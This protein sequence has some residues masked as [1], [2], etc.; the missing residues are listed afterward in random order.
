[1]L[2]MK[3]ELSKTSRKMSLILE[4]K[5]LRRKISGGLSHA[6]SS[7]NGT[8]K[9]FF[10]RF[11]LFACKNCY[12]VLDKIGCIKETRELWNNCWCSQAYNGMRPTIIMA[13]PVWRKKCSTTWYLAGPKAMLLHQTDWRFGASPIFYVWHHPK[14]EKGVICTYD[15][16]TLLWSKGT[17]R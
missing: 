6:P 12:C 4:V 8:C 16:F 11:N 17:K 3:K 7:R 1:M 10:I 15:Y 14:R 9:W 13:T 5:I 2:R